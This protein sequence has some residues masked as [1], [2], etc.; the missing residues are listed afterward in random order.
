MKKQNVFE[1]G[2]MG[3]A[4]E[5]W[6]KTWGEMGRMRLSGFSQRTAPD[7]V[8]AVP[9]IPRQVQTRPNRGRQFS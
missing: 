3:Q 6:D 5:E 4:R 8:V 7:S 9:E 1:K 2:E